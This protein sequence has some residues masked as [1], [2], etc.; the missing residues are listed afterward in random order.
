MRK[1]PFVYVFVGE[2]YRIASLRWYEPDQVRRVR[3]YL[4]NS[5]ESP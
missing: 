3:F 4:L 1:A 5:A 2:R